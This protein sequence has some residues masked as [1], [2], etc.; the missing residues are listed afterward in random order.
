MND[1][2]YIQRRLQSISP[3]DTQ[4]LLV[5]ASL[6]ALPVAGKSVVRLAEVVDVEQFIFFIFSLSYLNYVMSINGRV[7]EESADYFSAR[8]QTM[9]RRVLVSGVSN[10]VIDIIECVSE[11]FFRR[12]SLAEFEKRPESYP[13]LISIAI[14]RLEGV[15]R[16]GLGVPFETAFSNSIA[17]DLDIL[18]HKFNGRSISEISLWLERGYEGGVGNNVSMLWRD[19]RKFISGLGPSWVIWVD[20]YDRILS[21]TYGFSVK[22]DCFCSVL[23]DV[24]SW[25]L[26]PAYI[27]TKIMKKIEEAR[28]TRPPQEISIGADVPLEVAPPGPDLLRPRPAAIEPVFLDG[29]LRLSAAPADGSLDPAILLASL[30]TLREG[31]R[32]L[33]AE[34]ASES[35]VNQRPARRMTDIAD[36]I[37]DTVPTSDTVFVLGHLLGELDSFTATVNA[38]WPDYLAARYL[39]IKLNLDRTLRR[40]PQWRAFIEDPAHAS[41]TPAEQEGATALAHGVAAAARSPEVAAIVDPAVPNLLDA[42]ADQLAEWRALNEHVGGMVEA[43]GDRLA[44]DLIES[45]DNILKALAEAALVAKAA[46][47]RHLSPLW[48]DYRSPAY[49]SLRKEMERLGAGTGPFLTRTVGLLAPVAFSAL[50]APVVSA[51]RFGWLEGA[52]VALGCT[53]GGG[54]VVSLV[55]KT[56]KAEVTKE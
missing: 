49:T 6:R 12:I 51:G 53:V 16:F 23:G 32:E 30:R 1:S 55:R 27:N 10:G 39:A 7:S 28:S 14:R 36:R 43:T 13:R 48:D 8:L 25:H 24:D 44:A 31:L 47:A 34:I 3:V 19:F 38:E 54:K 26:S 17:V 52:L 4:V 11:G 56:G 20:W 40:F 9:K 46:S 41:L 42:L 37:G 33:A 35:Q 15:G 29:R 2:S 50:A 45:V 21:G 22:D 18:E 5:R